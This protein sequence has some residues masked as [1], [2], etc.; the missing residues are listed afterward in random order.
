MEK[1][2]LVA[3]LAVGLVL[4]G[5]VLGTNQANPGQRAEQARAA[6]AEAR[7]AVEAAERQRALWTTAQDALKDAE[8][9]LTQKDYAAAEHLARFAAEQAELGIEQLRYPHFQ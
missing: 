6:V 5:E 7:T 4:A 3:C 9:A 2:M 8:R 1:G